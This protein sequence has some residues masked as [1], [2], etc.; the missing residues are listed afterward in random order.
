[1]MRKC[2]TITVKT[3]TISYRWPYGAGTRVICSLCLGQDEPLHRSSEFA[4][5]DV[6]GGR[7]LLGVVTSAISRV[8]ET[9]LSKRE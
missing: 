1:M 4:K 3:R 8:R 6:V 5:N 9:S 2:C 7:A